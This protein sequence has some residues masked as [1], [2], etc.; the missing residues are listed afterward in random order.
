[1]NKTS[2][3]T[4]AVLLILIAW[5]GFSYYRSRN[6]MPVVA[7]TS[8]TECEKAGYPI[9]ESYPRQC[10][11][12]DGKTY[13]EQIAIK[14]TYSNATKDLIVVDSPL[15]GQS[16]TKTFS[17]TGK[18]RGTWYFEASFPIKVVDRDG[19]ILFSAPAQAQGDWMTEDFAPFK[20]DITLKS[21]YTGEATLILN[22]DNPSGLSEKEASVSIPIKIN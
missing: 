1:M 20:V 17:V 11:T 10:K 7:I 3:I 5:F 9:M 15:P 6:V 21:T 16:V 18:A 13:I 4:G 14:A 22:K 2:I 19:T 12:T 8:F